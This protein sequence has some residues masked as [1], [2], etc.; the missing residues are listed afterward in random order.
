MAMYPSIEL[1]RGIAAWMVLTTHYAHF[2][3]PEPS[4]LNFFWTGVDFFFVISGFVFAR[5]I[6]AGQLAVLPYLIRRV[7]RIYPLYF[8]SLLLY[9]S[10]TPNHSEKWIFFIKHLFFLHTTQSIEEAFFFNAAYWSLPVEMEFYLLIPILAIFAVRS[11]YFLLILLLSFLL[12]RIVIA[13][14]FLDSFMPN[15][16]AILNVH[17]P[18]IL[19]EF[20]LGVL[21]FQLYSRFK[22]VKMAYLI[23]IIAT[24]I[25]MLSALALYFSWYGDQGIDQ[26]FWF[27]TYFNFLCALGYSILLFPFLILIQPKRSFFNSC[28]LFIGNISY[29]V[30]LFHNLIPLIMKSFGYELI[31]VTAY[32]VYSGLVVILA[33]FFYYAVE[34]PTR[35][36]GRQL[37]TKIDRA[38]SKGLN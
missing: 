30:Y 17:L 21:L 24:G 12:F 2:L 1:F 15:L 31:G 18:G 25:I 3:I 27:K 8:C 38:D 13:F 34:K 23:L 32:L 22:H 14:S 28:C 9:F 29:G 37:A 35:G 16:S 19:G 20:L 10:F 4:F 26:V 5:S 6:F 36:W 11:R 7:F 33:L